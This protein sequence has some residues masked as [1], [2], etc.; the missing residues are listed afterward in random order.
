MHL[1]WVGKDLP[2]EI[3][4]STTLGNTGVVRRIVSGCEIQVGREVLLGDLIEMEI[5]DY[6][7]ED[8]LK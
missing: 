7:V 5:S 8:L 6:D 3:V 2:Y 1:S 4:V